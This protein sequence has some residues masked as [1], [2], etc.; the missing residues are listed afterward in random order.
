MAQCDT[1]Y[2]VYVGLSAW[3]VWKHFEGKCPWLLFLMTRVAQHFAP[4]K[5]LKIDVPPSE[6]CDSFINMSV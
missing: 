6:S 1:T 3:L 2:D 4:N 5:S